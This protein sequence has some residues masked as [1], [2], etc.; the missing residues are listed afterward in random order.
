MPL[1]VDA[2]LRQFALCPGGGWCT[3][4][5]IPSNAV[6]DGADAMLRSGGIIEVLSASK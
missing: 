2:A 1:M 4:E 3:Y 5:L 6:G